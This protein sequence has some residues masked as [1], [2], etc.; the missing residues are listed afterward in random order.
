M[1]S[2]VARRQLD[3]TAYREALI[4]RQGVGRQVRSNIMNAARHGPRQRIVFPEGEQTKIIRAAARVQE[5]NIGAPILLGREEQ[6]R[7]KIEELGLKFSPRIVNPLALTEVERR[8]YAD[9]LYQLRKRKG[10]SPALAY[11]Q[12]ASRRYFGL[13]MLQR[14]E[15]DAFLGG[16][17]YE[18]PQIVRP[19]LQIFPHAPGRE[20]GQWRLLDGS[21]GA[22]VPIHRRHCEYRS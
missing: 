22:S 8:D 13:M 20:A 5:E 16:L 11:S 7:G 12:A 17:S 6:I 10:V 21:E 9:E 19:A 1:Q 18:Y 4:Q 3:L 2:G 14:G 15:A